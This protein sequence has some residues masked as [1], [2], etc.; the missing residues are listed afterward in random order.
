MNESEKTIKESKSENDENRESKLSMLY[1]DSNDTRQILNDKFVEVFASFAYFEKVDEK[2]SQVDEYKEKDLFFQIIES[3]IE[4]NGQITVV[5]E[6]KHIDNEYTDT[7]Y[8]HFSGLHYPLVK[9]CKRLSFFIG[10]IEFVDLFLKSK[11]DYIQEIFVGTMV[12]KPLRYGFIGR[13]LLDP[14]K[15]ISKSELNCS[16]IYM[17]LGDYKQHIAG[18]ELS[19]S[20]FPFSNQ[21]SC[22]TTCAE[23]T[24][25][26]IIDYFSSKY[27]E[28]KMALPSEI[29][30]IGQ[31]YQYQR[32][33]PSVG[34]NYNV[35][36]KILGEL[37]FAPRI[38]NME[39]ISINPY[40][41]DERENEIRRIMHYYIESGIPVGVNVEPR[42]QMGVS[43]H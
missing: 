33:T 43:G 1:V 32:A 35:L 39:S 29:K 10:K 26:N 2:T 30:R 21:D 6:H 40:I 42:K 14:H 7:Y 28:Y 23:I 17:R 38:Y 16:N 8:N 19:V 36:S 13:T 24:I 31:D 25:L 12:L 15:Y 11:R 9:Y 41:G 27:K 18:A 4:K 37:G 20:A 34:L 5:I 3:I 22:Y